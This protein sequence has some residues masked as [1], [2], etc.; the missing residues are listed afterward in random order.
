MSQA[1]Q[2]RRTRNTSERAQPLSELERLRLRHP[3]G[4]QELGGLRRFRP[5]APRLGHS[6]TTLEKGQPA[7]WEVVDQQLEQ[8]ERGEPCLGFTAERDFAE[9]EVLPDHELEP[10]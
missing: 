3:D 5:D 10:A 8:D 7:S 4:R 6:F 2:E 1:L 9:V